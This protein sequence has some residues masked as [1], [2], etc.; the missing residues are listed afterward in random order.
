MLEL[1]QYAPRP[2]DSARRWLNWL[3]QVHHE[4]P[5]AVALPGDEESD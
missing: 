3:Y 2:N 5:K 4:A 1:Q